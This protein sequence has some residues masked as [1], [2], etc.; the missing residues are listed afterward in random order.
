[1]RFRIRDLLWLMVL[2]AV[3]C[4]RERERRLWESQRNAML[5]R[6]A[7]LEEIQKFLGG[8]EALRDFVKSA[9]AANSKRPPPTSVTV[10]K[11]PLDRLKS[12]SQERPRNEA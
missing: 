9:R 10:P 6:S 5:E 1:M 4:V 12:K 7:D 8:N 2:V 3:I 11:K